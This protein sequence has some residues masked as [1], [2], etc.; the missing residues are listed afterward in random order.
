MSDSHDTLVRRAAGWLRRGA[1]IP[2]PNSNY[3]DRQNVSCAVVLT[4]M[5]CT[6]RERPDA[7]GWAWGGR[8]SIL[9]ECK[10]T[11]SDFLADKKKSH[12]K[13]VG[14]GEYR[15]YLV[16]EGVAT[17]VDL[18][19]KWGLIEVQGRKLVVTQLAERQERSMAGEMALLWSL[20]RRAQELE[21]AKPT[22]LC[23]LAAPTDAQN[24]GT[25]AEE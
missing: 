15:Y 14:V 4:E 2:Y 25:A 20:G 24:S 21:R 23:V 1:V 5:Y 11:R 8:I 9:V 6:I 22:A 7:I 16:N 17:A 12:R 19:E 3:S 13:R 10:A 18:P